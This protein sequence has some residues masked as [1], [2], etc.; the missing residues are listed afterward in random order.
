M[1]KARLE[2]SMDEWVSCKD[3]AVDG[4]GVLRNQHDQVVDWIASITEDNDNSSATNTHN[5]LHMEVLEKGL[6]IVT[7][8]SSKEKEKIVFYAKKKIE[9]LERWL[10]SVLYIEFIKY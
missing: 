6:H 7:S 2:S 1:H 9:S 10:R 3:T 5:M 4:Y 8:H